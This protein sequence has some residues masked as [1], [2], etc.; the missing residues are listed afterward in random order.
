MERERYRE[1]GK[2]LKGQLDELQAQYNELEDDRDEGRE[3]AERIQEQLDE[4]ITARGDLQTPFSA[5]MAMSTSYAVFKITYTS[6][7]RNHQAMFIAGGGER[8]GHRYH[9]VGGTHEGMCYEL[10]RPTN[11]REKS[12]TF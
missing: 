11:S 8:A 10:G 9:V 5:S 1:G 6:V 7:P 4:V 12:K 3:R 2:K